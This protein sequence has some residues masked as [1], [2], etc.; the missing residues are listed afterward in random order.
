MYLLT[1]SVSFSIIN[2]PSQSWLKPNFN[3]NPSGSSSSINILT[4][5]ALRSTHEIPD[6]ITSSRNQSDKEKK[7]K[8]SVVVGSM[9]SCNNKTTPNNKIQTIGTSGEPQQQPRRQVR[10]DFIELYISFSFGIA[11]A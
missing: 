1:L 11:H 9:S 4:R 10:N 8:T 6:V 7:L 5:D 2:R 3:Y